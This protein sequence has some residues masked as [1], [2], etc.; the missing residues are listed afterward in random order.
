MSVWLHTRFVVT[1]A[2]RLR[3]FE[4]CREKARTSFALSQSIM[5]VVS[6][7]GVDQLIVVW[8]SI[9]DLE[10]AFSHIGRE[11]FEVCDKRVRFDRQLP[12]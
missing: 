12:G 1:V 10:V 6:R 4:A 7:G 5:R 2:P 9:F 8:T 3:A 11:L